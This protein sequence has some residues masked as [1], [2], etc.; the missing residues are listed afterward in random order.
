[1]LPRSQPMSRNRRHSRQQIVLKV[2]FESPAGFRSDFLSNISSGGLRLNSTL[3][4]GQRF[5]LHISFFGFVEPIQI[6]AEVQWSIP[7][8]APDGPASGLAFIDPSP[9]T[10]AWLADILEPSTVIRS[11]NDL[12]TR[13]VLLESEPFLRDVYS[14][15]VRNW[16]ELREEEPLDLVVHSNPAQWMLDVTNTRAELGILDLDDM[17]GVAMETYRR[18]RAS[19]MAAEMPLILLGSIENVEPFATLVDDALFCL[20][21]PLKFGVL[22][23]TVRV[24]ACGTSPGL[25]PADDDQSVD[26]I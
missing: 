18:V 5:M 17:P 11:I 25:E 9:G 4:V 2:E 13:V 23:N 20:R 16:A 8:S 10:A 7:A 15:E 21:K 14:Q 6:E 22:M 26:D 24:L 19:S 1:M 12:A 3:E